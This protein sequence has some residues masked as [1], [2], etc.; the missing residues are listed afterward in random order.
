MVSYLK[1]QLQIQEMLMS[2]H[3]QDRTK[4]PTKQNPALG[5]I[6]PTAYLED[7]ASQ[8]NF[9]L[10][11]A[12]QL[13]IDDKY[14]DFYRQMSER[15][16]FIICDN[17]AF[18]LGESYDPNRLVELADKCKA[19]AIVL[20]DYPF[21]NYQKT[22]DAAKQM[23]S[24]VYENGFYTCFVPQS[25]QG[26]LEGWIRS[27]RWGARS[28]MVDIVGMSILGMPNAI[29]HIPKSYA[30]VVLTQILL[31]RGFFDF[32]SYH[33]YLG[34]NSGMALEVPPLIAM[35]A[36]NSCD[37]SNPVWHAILGHEYTL[38][39]DSYLSVKK[40]HYPVDFNCPY[41]SDDDT[42]RRIQKNLGMS[43]GLFNRSR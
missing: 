21:Q 34:A 24:T 13:D 17:G 41:L 38:N 15:G 11:L 6:T 39:A 8:S 19:H 4:I 32:N 23:A 33:H 5:I 14:A 37:S 16:D 25:E 20:P 3:F 10:V 9:H 2:N 30:R 22:I 26:D 42:H 31:D 12:H 1:I 29:P 27:Y 28:D 7:Y 43:K 35:N 36:M 18:E 40:V